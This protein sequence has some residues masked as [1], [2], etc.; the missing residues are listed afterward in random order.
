MIS[1]LAYVDRQQ[2]LGKTDNDSPF[3]LT[4]IRMWK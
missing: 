1:P 2:R 4:L 3:C